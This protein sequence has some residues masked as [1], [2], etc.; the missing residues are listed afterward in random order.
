MALSATMLDQGPSDAG[1]VA[2]STPVLRCVG[3]RKRFEEL[4][5][6]DGVSLEIAAGEC[7]GLLGPNGA[8]KTTSISMMCGLLASDG[9]TVEIAGQPM[10]TTSVAAK[11]ALG[12][13]P[14]DLA[15]Y[16]DMTARENLR[17]FARLYNMRG[18]AAKV[19]IDAVLELVGLS[20]R[21]DDLVKEYSG[22][23]QRRL[24]LGLG[25]L[26]E[27]RLL[28]LDEP[29]VGVDPQSR[30]SILSS[31]E[32][33]GQEGMGVLYTTHYMEEAERFCDRIGIIDH[34]K[35]IAEGTHRELIALV[36]GGDRVLLSASGDLQ[37]AA[38]AMREVRG[39][40]QVVQT[41]D[42]LELA[43]EDAGTLLPALLERAAATQTS[44]SAVEAR[45]SNL[46]TVFLHLTGR[47]LRD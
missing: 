28:I 3:L 18:R 10:T 7:Y 16:L 4:T 45:S 23:M 31:I 27:P 34:G 20:E 13:V 42:G 21:A 36:G 33:L 44:L 39:V 43:V 19:R 22:G 41:D 26:H 12:Y 9:G 29:T 24:N 11:A 38:E 5:A 40:L 32:Q 47:A 1:I 14:Q 17:F 2:Q 35:L 6:V 25:L 30:N 15:I 46:E 8:G 37:R